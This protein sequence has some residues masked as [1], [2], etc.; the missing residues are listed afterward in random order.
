V[1]TCILFQAF[2][3][4]YFTKIALSRLLETAGSCSKLVIADSGS[5]DGTREY[6][7]ELERSGVLPNAE[8]WYYKKNYG[9]DRPRAHF[10]LEHEHKYDFLG[11][12]ANDVLTSPGWVPAFEELLDKV[13]QIGI[14]G[15]IDR[16]W[17]NR[18]L[19][20]KDDLSY[21]GGHHFSWSDGYWLLRASA[22]DKIRGREISIQGQKFVHPGVFPFN[23]FSL[24]QEEYWNNIRAAGLVTAC[25]PKHNVQ[26][27]QNTEDVRA[28]WHKEYTV[29]TKVTYCV[30]P[31]K[32]EKETEGV[33]TYRRK[34]K[35]H[36]WDTEPK[37]VRETPDIV[38]EVSRGKKLAQLDRGVKLADVP[39]DSRNSLTIE[40][41]DWRE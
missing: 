34:G 17:G 41:I 26:F 35:Q 28:G 20:K 25:H 38:R 7:E 10:L 18:E 30:E 39:E 8:F 19:V 21:Y 5:V 6:L 1:R 32:Y 40:T 16:E 24:T 23:S 22:I 15:A 2:N 9:R 31:E 36:T 12:V 4:L 13:P 3:R 33:V 37:L 29:L 27:V 11:C 14:V